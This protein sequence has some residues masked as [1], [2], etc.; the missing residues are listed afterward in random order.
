MPE[1]LPPLPPIKTD[2]KYGYFPWWPEDGDAW[3]HPEDVATARSM[4]PSPRI[5][6][7]DGTVDGIA[8]GAGD[9]AVDFVVMHYGDVRLRVRRTLWREINAPDYDLGDWV[10]V[11]TRGMTN[12]PHTG[13]V[14]ELHWDDRAGVVRYCLALADGTVLE[15]SYQADDLKP[16]EPPAHEPEVRREP[17]PDDGD[18]LGLLGADS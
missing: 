3:V 18:D 1:D 14:R 5:W 16:V 12:E 8:D 7:R 9:A 10:E 11:R 15:R 2:P 13:Q 4:I 6:R 17:M